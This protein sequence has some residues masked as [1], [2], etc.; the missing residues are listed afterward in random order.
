MPLATA[1]EPFSDPDWVFEPKS[2]A[3]GGAPRSVR[4][5]QRQRDAPPSAG[6]ATTREPLS[7]PQVSRRDKQTISSAVSVRANSISLSS[8]VGQRNSEIHVRSD[9]WFLPPRAL[10]SSHLCASARFTSLRG[11]IGGVLVS[12][13]AFGGTRS[14]HSRRSRCSVS[15]SSDFLRR[16]SRGVGLPYDTAC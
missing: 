12:F 10:V 16:H 1:R 14:R 4:R 3:V 9:L 13:D 6:K 8:A 5:A 2:L 15:T 11:R 7:G